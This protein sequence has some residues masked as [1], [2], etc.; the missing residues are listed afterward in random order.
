MSSKNVLRAL[1]CTHCFTCLQFLFPLVTILLLGCKATVIGPDYAC[2]HSPHFDIY[3]QESQ[4]HLSQMPGIAERKERLLCF[5]DSALEVSFEG[6]IKTYLTSGSLNN[7]GGQ[8]SHTGVVWESR[9]YVLG[10]D[11]H[12]IVHVVAFKELGYISNRFILEGFAMAFE[13]TFENPIER[14][15]VLCNTDN[16]NPTLSISIAD[17]VLN[18]DFAYIYQN[19][20]R[21][22]AFIYYLKELYGLNRIKQFYAAAA[23][24]EVSLGTSFTSIFGM[25]IQTGEKQFYSRYFAR[26]AIFSDSTKTQG[27]K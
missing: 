11:G 6:V 13:L 22:G 23:D 14:F 21:A 7:Y 12:E 1:H 26:T 5:I 9:L 27:V 19:Y 15:A 24:S 17:Q 2:Y 4:Y 3:F 20:C 25:S 10:D 8:A 16:L 18:N